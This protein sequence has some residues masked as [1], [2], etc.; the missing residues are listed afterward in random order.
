MSIYRTESGTIIQF[1]AVIGKGGEGTVYSLQNYSG[2]AAKIYLSGLAAERR[3]KISSMVAAKLHTSAS[4]R[5]I[6]Y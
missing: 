4:F 2:L 3:E 1:G 5:C 6:S